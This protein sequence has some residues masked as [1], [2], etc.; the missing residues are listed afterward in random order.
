M[1][2]YIETYQNRPT[3]AEVS[4]GRL[5]N[6]FEIVRS[7][8]GA[9]VKIMAMVKSN[10][11]G[12]GIRTV[13]EEFL[14]AGAHY[15]GVAYLEEAV[16]LRRS[17]I[18]AP[19]LVC[20]AINTDQIEDFLRNDIEITSSSIEKS[21]AISSTAKRLGKTAVV[22]LKIDTGMER[23]GVHWYNAEKFISRTLELPGITVKGIFS[24][25]AKAESDREFTDLQISRFEKVVDFMARKYMLP[26]FMH[27]ANSAAIISSPG[28]HFNMVRP[29]IMLY[30]YNP[31]GLDPNRNFGGRKLMPAMTLKTTVSYFK[32]C[33]PDTGISYNHTYAT[34]GQTRIVT[35][36][37]GYGDG[38]NRQLSNRGEVIIRGRRHPVVGAVCMDQ[39][40][41]DIGPDGTAYNGDDVLLFGE[42]NNDSIPLESLCG[43]IGTITYELLCAISS[44]VPRIFVD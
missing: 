44:R 12:H 21:E 14:K 13:S 39:I 5:R 38:Y 3:R 24:H 34:R 32:V 37:V 30:G 15:L 23:I 29:G 25:L 36:P 22:H 6:N 2:L 9:G 40:M 20:G 17:G 41:V 33:P 1:H 10:A 35:L 43:K 27:L 4:L 31:F 18:T 42:L 28:S 16:Y 11:Y 8:V 26:E 19:I 7:L